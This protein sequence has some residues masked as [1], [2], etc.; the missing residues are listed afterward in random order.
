MAKDETSPLSREVGTERARYSFTGEN[1]KAVKA[2]VKAVKG[3]ALTRNRNDNLAAARAA[4]TAK[5]EGA[6][7]KGSTR[8][9]KDAE[10]DAPAPAKSTRKRKS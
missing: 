6:A 10:A 7:A 2:V 1:D 8:K 3:G 4:K 5:A 9:A